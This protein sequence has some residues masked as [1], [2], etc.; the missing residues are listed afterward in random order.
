MAYNVSLP[1]E[2]AAE[3]LSFFNFEKTNIGKKKSQATE[4]QRLRLT[5][6]M[7]WFSI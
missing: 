4:N 1:D 2:V 3:E 7:S 6:V 5:A